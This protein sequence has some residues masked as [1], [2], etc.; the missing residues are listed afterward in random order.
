MCDSIVSENHFMIAY[1]PNKCKTERMCD[2]A[3][4]DCLATLKFFQGWFVTSKM[5]EHFDKSLLANDEILFF[6][7]DFNILS[8]IY[9]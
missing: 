2:K 7:E 3:V 8:Y 4:D 6:N 9:Y 1:C 5:F